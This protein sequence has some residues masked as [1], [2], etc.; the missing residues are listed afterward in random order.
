MNLTRESISCDKD[1]KFFQSLPITFRYKIANYPAITC[2]HG[3]PK[4][5]R[6]L[7]LDEKNNT[8]E[9]LENIDTEYLICAHT[10]FPCEM[11]QK[12]KYYFNSGCVG[13]TIINSNIQI[14]LTGID[15]SAEMVSTA[16]NKAKEI[17]KE[18]MWPVIEEK[19]FE[20]A[21]KELGIPDYRL[22]L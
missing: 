11:K 4:S 18:A 10:H 6:E 3:S 8:K 2:C 9:W 14:L 16:I 12:G 21:A 17:D 13:V 19:Y 22:I 5:T 15:H 7:L 1:F 20:E